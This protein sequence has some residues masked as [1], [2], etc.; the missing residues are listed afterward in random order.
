MQKWILYLRIEEIVKSDLHRLSLNVTDKI[1]L[2]RKDKYI[3]L[4]NRNIYNIWK[5]IKKSYKNNTFKMS[6]ST[7][8]EEFELPDGSY[9]TSNIRDYFKYIYIYFFFFTK[10]VLQR[11]QQTKQL[12]INKKLKNSNTFTH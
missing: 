12:T 2:R 9:S 11:Y 5:N 8:N 6:A 7:W 10:Y 4:S 1:D 3:A